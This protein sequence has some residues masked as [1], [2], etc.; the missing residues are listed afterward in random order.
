MKS[1]TRQISHACSV[2]GRASGFAA[3]VGSALLCWGSP[4]A[5]QGPCDGTPGRWGRPARVEVAV[6]A[7]EGALAG[8]AIDDL[9]ESLEGDLAEI[10]R[11][12]R[13]AVG[14]T[15]SATLFV[16]VPG[17]GLQLALRAGSGDPAEGEALL[18]A[19][20]GVG[21][22]EPREGRGEYP[23]F[24]CD[25]LAAHGA[26]VAVLLHLS[27][28]GAIL[29]LVLGQPCMELGSRT[30]MLAASGSAEER[31]S[32][33]ATALHD[34]L[35]ELVAARYW[36][37]LRLHG[38]EGLALSVDGEPV[39]RLPLEG[40]LCTSPGARAVLVAG[41]DGCDRLDSLEPGDVD[42]SPIP[43]ACASTRPRVYTWVA[44]GLAGVTL[45]AAVVSQV[46]SS[47]LVD[48]SE[49]S[50]DR[51]EAIDL[52]ASARSAAV[53]SNVL[54]GAAGALALGAVALFFFEDVGDGAA[55]TV[56]PLPE[57]GGVAALS[58]T[59]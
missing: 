51:Q 24:V 46:Q 1:R 5:A 31:A 3:L 39:G 55:V 47:G 19:R 36:S 48:D 42:W 4:G 16:P 12:L 23:S 49:Q 21:G 32:A 2:R 40:P 58:G 54:Y 6:L 38:A 17:A 18:L 27:N 13:R 22:V 43:K 44:A 30:V 45:A 37:S 57:G 7:A 53:R 9:R 34:R 41:D 29:K 26:E 11:P 33:Y 28:G 15:G 59:F 35:L 25:Q 56:Q 10:E 50:L 20:L 14:E 52:R 8:P